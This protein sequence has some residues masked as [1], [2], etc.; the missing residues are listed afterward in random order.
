MAKTGIAVVYVDDVLFYA[1]D[2]SEIAHVISNLQ[3][4]DIGICREGTAKGFLGVDMKCKKR[5]DG[6]QITLLQKGL[7]HH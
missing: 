1:K 5:V 2:D 3:H 7:T 6:T 4:A